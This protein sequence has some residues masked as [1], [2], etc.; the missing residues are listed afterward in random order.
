M[1]SFLQVGSEDAEYQI[2]VVCIRANNDIFLEIKSVGQH[3]TPVETTYIFHKF[4]GF[5]MTTESLRMYMQ[6]K[7]SVYEYEFT[8]CLTYEDKCIIRDWLLRH[9]LPLKLTRAYKETIKSR[10]T[11]L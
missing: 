2:D 6:G 7:L 1:A 8:H 5:C 11:L 4:L 10:R 9:T 3:Y